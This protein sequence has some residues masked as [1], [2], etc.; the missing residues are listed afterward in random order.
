MPRPPASSM[1]QTQAA[2]RWMKHTSLPAVLLAFGIAALQLPTDTLAK[3]KVSYAYQ[4]DPTF[5]AAVCLWALVQ[6][7]AFLL[8]LLASGARVVLAC[9]LSAHPGG[10]KRTTSRPAR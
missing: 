6:G 3:E 4:L 5:D 8:D 9:S 10:S 2:R 7:K 1:R